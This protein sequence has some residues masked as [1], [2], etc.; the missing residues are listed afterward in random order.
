VEDSAAISPDSWVVLSPPDVEITAVYSDSISIRQSDVDIPLQVTLQNSGGT[1]VILDSLILEETI[2]WYSVQ[3]P[4]FPQQLDGW[5]SSV[6][7]NYL[8]DVN[9]N[10]ATGMDSIYARAYYHNKFSNEPYEKRSVV[11][12]EWAINGASSSIAIISVHSERDQVSQE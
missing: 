12:H 3:N 8:L 4:Q 7:F 5:Q 11:Y 9:E 10:S 6:H 1:A 2:G